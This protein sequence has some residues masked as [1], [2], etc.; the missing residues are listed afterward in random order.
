MLEKSK[1]GTV[2]VRTAHSLN[3][4]PFII[5]DKRNLYELKNGEFGLANVAPTIAQIFGL[6]IPE[7]WEEGM[8]KTHK[9][10]M[11]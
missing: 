3:S 4:V 11:R 10:L 2:Q 5:Y 1:N 9:N 7:C 6:D 8:I